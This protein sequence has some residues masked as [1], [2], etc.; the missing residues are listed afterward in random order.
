[1]AGRRDT[2][3]GNLA[4][5]PEVR[6][7]VFQEASDLPGKLGDR[8]NIGKLTIHRFIRFTGRRVHALSL[9]DIPTITESRKAG[10]VVGYHCKYLRPRRWT[11]HLQRFSGESSSC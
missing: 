2:E 10:K 8:E 3:I 7:M 4:L 11:I 5:D 9:E 6:K 1:M